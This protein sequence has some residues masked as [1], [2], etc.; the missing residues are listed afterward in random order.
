MTRR[1]VYLLKLLIIT[2]SRIAFLRLDTKL[3]RFTSSESK[4]GVKWL[5]GHIQNLKTQRH[6]I[7]ADWNINIHQALWT[8]V[9]TGSASALTAYWDLNST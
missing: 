5:G 8:G 7:I 9:P 2:S 3:G 1:S 4:V 6:P